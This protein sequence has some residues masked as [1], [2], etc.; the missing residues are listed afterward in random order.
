LGKHPARHWNYNQKIKLG[1]LRGG[2]VFT[3]GGGGGKVGG[4]EG[5]VG[6]AQLI[7]HEVSAAAWRGGGGGGEGGRLLAN[8]ITLV[9]SGKR[10]QKSRGGRA[11]EGE[12]AGPVAHLNP[13]R[14]VRGRGGVVKKVNRV[15]SERGMTWGGGLQGG[16]AG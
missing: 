11:K 12:D 8:T 15:W 14:I 9:K 2:G 4:R 10:R 6:G 5:P 13:Q 1:G 7:C 3:G 16:K